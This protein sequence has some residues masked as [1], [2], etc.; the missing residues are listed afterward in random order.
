M[1]YSLFD[2][3]GLAIFPTGLMTSSV[4]CGPCFDD[5]PACEN[6]KNPD[7]SSLKASWKF[8]SKFCSFHS[9][10]PWIYYLPLLVLSVSL[11]L[12]GIKL[13][14]D[15]IFQSGTEI[16]TFHGLVEKKWTDNSNLAIEM[17]KKF[18]HGPSTNFFAC[19]VAK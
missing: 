1:C 16:Q 14:F 13:F 8:T 10:D 7:P 4:L 18:G 5:I 19:Y 12:L 6:H 11:T 15:S 17:E 9:V 2:F 3:L